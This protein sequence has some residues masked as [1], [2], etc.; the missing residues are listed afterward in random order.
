MRRRHAGGL[1]LER[2]VAAVDHHHLA[3]AGAALYGGAQPED[4]AG[5]GV[6]S[7]TTQDIYPW[8]QMGLQ[9]VIGGGTNRVIILFTSVGNEADRVESS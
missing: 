4:P 5:G 6:L 2:H 1:D 7:M 9:I 3:A 8:V